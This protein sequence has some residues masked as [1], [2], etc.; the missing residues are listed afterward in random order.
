[1]LPTH[2]KPN[3][4]AHASMIPEDPQEK[5]NQTGESQEARRLASLEYTVEEKNKTSISNKVKARTRG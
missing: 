2:V 3:T 4:A 5:G 1:M